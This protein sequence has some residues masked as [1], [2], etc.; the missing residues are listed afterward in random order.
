MTT[1]REDQPGLHL[2]SD[3]PSLVDMLAFQGIAE[4]LVDA[5]LDDALDP[6]A[7][8]VSGQW[9]S[10][11]TTVLRLIES[12]LRARSS[13]EA[14]ILVV[15]TEPWRYDPAVGAKESVIAEVLDALTRIH[16]PIV[17]GD[18]SRVP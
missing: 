7:L 8:G 1:D 5:L 2:W 11:K 12:E 4:T 6:V 14:K 17:V 13:K 9:G 3:E 18:V 10:G 15:V 16:R